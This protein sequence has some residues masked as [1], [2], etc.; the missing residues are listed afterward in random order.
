MK[1]VETLRALARF[2]NVVADHL[3]TLSGPIP[4]AAFYGTM[5]AFRKRVGYLVRN[6]GVGVPTE[7]L[8]LPLAE[9][10]AVE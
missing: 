1:E 9:Y 7:E 8:P 6:Y 3:D 4:R 5:Y 2:L 10:A